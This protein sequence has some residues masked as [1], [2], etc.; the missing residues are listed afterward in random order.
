MRPVNAA[1]RAPAAG[2]ADAFLAGVGSFGEG[3][4][5]LVFLYSLY[6]PVGTLAGAGSGMHDQTVI[7]PQ[8]RRLGAGLVLKQP[9]RMLAAALDLARQTGLTANASGSE[10]TLLCRVAVL[11]TTLVECGNGGRFC[12]ELLARV[13]WLRK[14][15]G[16]LVGERFYC[17]TNKQAWEPTG[18][19]PNT[20]GRPYETEVFGQPTHAKEELGKDEIQQQLDIEFGQAIERLAAA[21]ASGK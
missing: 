10:R 8:L 19:F 6:L 15:D 2:P 5:A 7:D 12:L 18:L 16:E 3:G 13:R 9:N 21:I 20:S 17:V 14:D 1:E 4:A 11:K